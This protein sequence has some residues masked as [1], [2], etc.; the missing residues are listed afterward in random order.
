MSTHTWRKYQGALL[1][2]GLPHE[3]APSRSEACE[4]LKTQGGM[5][6]RW[7]S[8]FD[9]CS[10]T[11][12][13]Y[14]ICDSYTPLDKLT[15][16]QRYRVNKGLRHCETVYAKT[17]QRTDTHAVYEL[18]KASF[19]DYPKAYRPDLQEEEFTQYIN[20]LLQDQDIDIWLVYSK[21]NQ[22]V[23][24]C[25]CTKAQDIVWLAQVKVPTAYL[26]MEVNAA[27]VY[28]LCSYYLQEQHYRYICDGERNIK[29][30]TNYQDFLIRVLNFRYAYCKLH[31]VYK[32]WM[33]I[34]VNILY[35]FRG[36]LKTMRF[37]HP[38]VYNIYC[39]LLQEEIRRSFDE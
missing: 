24:Y 35:P 2:N 26:R 15:A 1:W 7:T 31:I 34:A 13:W 28:T 32:G 27:L 22:L 16:K 3:T 17:D 23:G 19:E 8:D 6:A 25:Q 14:C 18:V 5:F 30:I 21:E 29:H 37:L 33:R 11:G 20:Q 10:P 36:M 9:S 4:A 39:V 38:T 12:W